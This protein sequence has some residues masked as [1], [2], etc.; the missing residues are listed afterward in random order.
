MSTTE[1]DPDQPSPEILQPYAEPPAAEPAA[2][3]PPPPPR[4]G[5]ALVALIPDAGREPSPGTTDAQAQAVWCAVT[6]LWHPSLLTGAAALPRIES[7]AAPTPPEA[8]E[9]R[10]V[11][12]GMRDR[13]P[14]GY[15]TQAE[16]AGAVL[17]ESGPDRDA[18]VR[19]IRERLGVHEPETPPG[20]DDFLALGMARWMVRDLTSSMGRAE[21]LKEDAL[22][23]EALAAADAWAKGDAVAVASR[24]K[25]AFEILTQ[26][27]EAVYS[28]DAYLV[29]LCL[30]DP[31]LPAG[32]I[33]AMLATPVPF[34][35]LAQ[36]RAI[37][38]Q[39]KLDPEAM[40]RLGQAI[41][42]GWVDVVGGTYDEAEDPLLPI[43]ST[44]WQ[45]RRGGEVYREHLEERN[46][47]TY[48]RRRFGLWPQVPMLARRSGYRFALHLGLDA[49][50][51]P[52]R[53]EPK[54]IW[55]SPEGSSVETMF[56]LPMAADRPSQGPMFPWKLAATMRT[57]TVAT[58]PLVHWPSPVA[59]WYVDLRR[60]STHSPV[61]GRWAT[62][63]D[64]FQLTDRPY[65]TFRPE[66]DEY[67]SPYL[68]QAAASRDEA[69]ISRFPDHHRLRARLESARW[70]RSMAK[71]VALSK[72]EAALDAEADQAERV[73]IEEA[74]AAIETR[75]HDEAASLVDALESGWAAELAA[76]ISGESTD[77]VRPGYLVF[78]P[79]AVPRKVAVVL[80][81]ASADLR[82]EGALVAAQLTDEGVVAVIDL[83]AFGFAWIPRETAVD[84]PPAESGGVSATGRVIKNEMI[85]V[86]F[87]DATGGIRGIMAVGESTA[88]LAQQ[89]VMTGLKG[90]QG[91]ADSSRMRRERF[92]VEFAG[93]A[94]AQAVSTSALVDYAGTVLARVELRCRLWVGRPIA[95]LELTV[96][97]LDPTWADWAARSDPWSHRLAF[98]WAWPDATSMLRRLAFLSPESTQA[99]RPETPDAID[100][101]TRRQ[102][103]AM[104]FGGLP[105]HAKAGARMLDTVLI[106]GSEEGRTFRLAVTLDSEHPHR[107]AHDVVTPAVV[108]PT[109]A[110]P[111][112]MGNRGW[113]TRIDSQAV[114]V[115]HV[116]FLAETYDGRG[117]G[118]DLH[119]VETAGYHARCRVQFFRNPT[120]ARQYDLQGE[121]IGDLS[122]D[123]DAV[124]LDLMA[125]ELFRV[126]VAFG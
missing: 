31:A 84:L 67:V 86:E 13:L 117:W 64:Y 57:D 53:R 29:D 39:A 15:A 105:Y 106:A 95:E 26:A 1:A 55:E 110:G 78:N 59:S 80:P 6:A 54:R 19:E 44:L 124:W 56:R 97:D 96:R 100:V 111:P 62:V 63:N 50:R 81:D 69:P 17:L 7:I 58:L 27:R 98:R 76:A 107:Q 71:G 103:A 38:A 8:H 108:V 89:T 22:A 23:R 34:T 125:G 118:L 82:P 68:S 52:I 48:A 12:G 79:I 126:V 92:E 114:A 120:W 102:R 25:S 11:V 101:S 28:V 36:A 121:P 33:A 123:G 16:D 115:T 65:E 43:E 3:P 40:P 109:E 45:F 41:T 42:D 61:F 90:P 99:E 24:L 87:D 77:G 94:L 4:P 73:A 122:V 14:S 83:P 88:R 113:L 35:F 5:R 21:A 10:L 47:E 93:P 112:P 9:V 51:F 32:G 72:P 46:V 37:E 70:L 75:R 18:T 104:L 2:E 20:A 74:E 30:L 116:G 85:E 91:E 66:P 49:G 119:L 60:V